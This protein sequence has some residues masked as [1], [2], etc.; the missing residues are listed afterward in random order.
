MKQKND[1]KFKQLKINFLFYS[2]NII[3]LK[4]NNIFIFIVM[5]IIYLWVLSILYCQLNPQTTSKVALNPNYNV[6][7][8]MN[9]MPHFCKASMVSRC[10][11]KSPY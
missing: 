1:T 7:G 5:F 3:K 4:I 8:F 6:V 10:L 2:M 11:V 9:T